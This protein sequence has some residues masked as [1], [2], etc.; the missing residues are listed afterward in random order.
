M[1]STNQEKRAARALAAVREIS[2]TQALRQV[3]EHGARVAERQGVSYS[4]ALRG[5]ERAAKQRLQAEG[6]PLLSGTS[7][8]ASARPPAKKRLS[9]SCCRATLHASAAQGGRAGSVEIEARHQAH[10]LSAERAL[11]ARPGRQLG[12]DDVRRR[13]AQV[14]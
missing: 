2:Y 5:I 9:V 1:P 11:V 14:T 3:R 13:H 7:D 10:V 6:R 4:L 12:R 8:A